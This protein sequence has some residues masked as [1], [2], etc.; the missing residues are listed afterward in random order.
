MNQ[1]NDHIPKQLKLGKTGQS[2]PAEVPK[3]AGGTGR[4]QTNLPQINW[5]PSKLTITVILLT[6]PYLI[7]T[8]VAFG[9][10]NNLIG[11]VFIG[12]GL[13]VVGM[14]FLLRYIERNDW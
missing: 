13:M 11:F 4:V 8:L 6:I 14:Y 10:G 12:I 3:A 5:T 7:A 9:V 1:K 2:Q